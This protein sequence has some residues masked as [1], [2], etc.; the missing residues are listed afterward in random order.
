[1]IS[2]H[3]HSGQEQNA[4]TKCSAVSLLCRMKKRGSQNKQVNQVTKLIHFINR[5]KKCQRRLG[6]SVNFS[7][8]K[9]TQR[10][11]GRH[12][13]NLRITLK[14]EGDG[15]QCDALFDYGYTFTLLFC[16]DPPPKEYTDKSLSTLHARVLIFFNSIPDKHHTCNLYISAIFQGCISASKICVTLW[17]FLN[18]WKRDPFICTSRGG[19]KQK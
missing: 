16:H 8:D 19:E 3:A 13:E 7:V 5:S 2:C 1:M 6:I 11:Q 17:C 9:Q 10:M 14:K 18:K 12:P 15:S 4:T